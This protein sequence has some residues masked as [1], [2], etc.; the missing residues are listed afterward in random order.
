MNYI[1]KSEL[2]GLVS[3][4]LEKNFGELGFKLKKSKNLLI[5]I[6]NGGQIIIDYRVLDAYNFKRNEVAWK[7]EI[8]FFI[9]YNIVHEW[10]ENIEDKK[11]NEFNQNWTF[12]T[13]LNETL[14]NDLIIDVD[15]DENDIV[16]F[17]NLIIYKTKV[18]LNKFYNSNKTLTQLY[19]NKIPPE[20]NTV[21]D[22]TKF[23]S[24]NFRTAIE[25]LTMNRILNLSNFYILV[26]IFK[27]KLEYFF[28]NGDPITVIY[29][30]RIDE[31][32]EKLEKIDFSN[33]DDNLKL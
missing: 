31:I 24:F 26:S 9:R 30:H 10:F 29:F 22:L 12:G 6:L 15:V 17:L 8:F 11:K 13:C 5:K 14:D 7:V 20:L 1:K 33:V 21:N 23:D 3:E 28:N 27:K 18:G 4:N 32:I 25:C 19:M 16:S 2:K